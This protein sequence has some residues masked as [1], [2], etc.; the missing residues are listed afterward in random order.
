[1][2]SEERYRS[3]FDSNK[4]GILVTDMDGNILDANQAYL[5]MLGYR[6]EEL[7]HL[8][9]QQLTPGE[10]ATTGGRDSRRTNNQERLF[11]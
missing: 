2:R 7:K 3:L 6:L 4:D 1:M 11:R 8:N 5:E 10:V 9:Y